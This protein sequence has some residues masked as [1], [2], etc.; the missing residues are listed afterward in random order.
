VLHHNRGVF[1]ENGGL[2]KYRAVILV[3]EIYKIRDCRFS[4]EKLWSPNI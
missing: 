2:K 4:K 3:N 1:D